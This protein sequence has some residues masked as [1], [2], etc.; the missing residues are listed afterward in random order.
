MSHG[1]TPGS[2]SPDGNKEEDSLGWH[3]TV[4]VTTTYIP[5]A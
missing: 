2:F 5:L 4:A 1:T 3:D